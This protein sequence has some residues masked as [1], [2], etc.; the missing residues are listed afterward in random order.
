M[1]TRLT[2]VAL[3]TK[4]AV[5]SRRD[6][7]MLVM[8]KEFVKLKG[9][10]KGRKLVRKKVLVMKNASKAGDWLRLVQCLHRGVSIKS[11]LTET[12]IADAL[13]C[14]RPLKLL[15][16]FL[17]HVLVVPSSTSNAVIRKPPHSLT[18]EL[19]TNSHTIIPFGPFLTSSTQVLNSHST[20]YPANRS[21]T[22]NQSLSTASSMSL[23]L[24]AFLHQ[25]LFPRIL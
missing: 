24:S 23:P 19:Q 18:T 7:Q 17:L 13:T 3:A 25:T 4:A 9:I 14:N 15:T 12:M 21:T 2:I 6:A 5:F 11:L 20:T 16:T 22:T 10:L 1:N 8:T